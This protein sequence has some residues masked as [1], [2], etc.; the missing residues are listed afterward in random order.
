MSVPPPGGKG[1]MNVTGLF[2]YPACDCAFAGHS[3]G[4]NAKASDA[5]SKGRDVMAAQYFIFEPPRK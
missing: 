5:A 1:T 3:S 2:G 4:N